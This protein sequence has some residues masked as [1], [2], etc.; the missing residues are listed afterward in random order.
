MS[1]DWPSLTSF[2]SSLPLLMPESLPTSL[3]RGGTNNFCP[4]PL[5]PS[6][7]Y[8][9]SPTQGESRVFQ[10]V[11]GQRGS[12]SDWSSLRRWGELSGTRN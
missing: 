4:F 10:L 6:L 9:F 12:A 5:P 11:E 1:S 3:G 8:A 7:P 2:P